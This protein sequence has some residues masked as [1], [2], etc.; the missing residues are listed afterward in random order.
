MQATSGAIRAMKCLG[1]CGMMWGAVWLLMSCGGCGVFLKHSIPPPPQNQNE[2]VF[3]ETPDGWMLAIRRYKPENKKPGSLPV[4]L[5]HGYG[6]NGT[7]WTLED[8][9][10][11]AAYLRAKGY[12]TYVPDLRGMGQSYHK[13]DPGEFTGDT[14]MDEPQ[15]GIG[16]WTVD[17]YAFTDVP[18][19]IDKVRELSGAPKVCWVGH[20][21]GGM[22]MYAYLVRAKGAQDNVQTFVAVASPVFMFQPAGRM[23][24]N[25]R[26][27]VGLL[28][29]VNIKGICDNYALLPTGIM[30]FDTLYY[31]R[32]N[33]T[34]LT[35][36]RMNAYCMEDLPY[37]V[38][39]QL[40][41]M[42]ATGTFWSADGKIDY[43]ERLHEITIPM[44]FVS[45]KL[46]NMCPAG[47][48]YYAYRCVGSGHKEFIH[49]ARANED[50]ADYGHC[51]LI[52]GLSAPEEVFPKIASWL[53]RYQPGSATQPR[54]QVRQ[55]RRE[56]LEGEVFISD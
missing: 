49:F 53:D 14:L 15:D 22:I 52:W 3:A 54:Y 26:K 13:P 9:C 4:I 41:Q 25:M 42:V 51:D 8:R 39:L 5:C 27:N 35:V 46:D 1:E 18:A 16:D 45:G 12:D 23:M 6:C 10:D 33:V 7:F 56:S 48:A 43:C 40:N 34:D 21:M 36:R 47:M 50:K 32:A 31:N 20:S 37:G 29:T 44:Y 19:I 2:E 28:K 55:M 11:F 38:S 17:D 24:Q 30:P